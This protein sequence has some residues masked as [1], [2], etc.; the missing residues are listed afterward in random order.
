MRA[1]GT[2]QKESGV[3]LEPNKSRR[4]GC[5]RRAKVMTREAISAE[6]ELRRVGRKAEPEGAEGQGSAQRLCDLNHMRR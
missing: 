3:P 5:E 1:C 2:G 6:V 4:S